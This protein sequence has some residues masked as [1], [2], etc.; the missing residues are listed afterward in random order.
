MSLG[1]IPCNRELLYPE[2]SLEL[3]TV[4]ANV[5]SVF[6]Y[7]DTRGLVGLITFEK[8]YKLPLSSQPLVK[9]VFLE[10]SKAVKFDNFFIL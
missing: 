8:D 9:R 10:S 7:K 5:L 1:V 2:T 4:L 6:T 3:H